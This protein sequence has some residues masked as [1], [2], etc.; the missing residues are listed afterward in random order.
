MYHRK[1]SI[2]NY[3]LD[4]FVLYAAL[5]VAGKAPAVPNIAITSGDEH[6]LRSLRIIELQAVLDAIRSMV[7][8]LTAEDMATDTTPTPVVFTNGRTV[9]YPSWMLNNRG[10]ELLSVYQTILGAA[11][12]N[13]ATLEK[14]L[15]R[16]RLLPNELAD[17]LVTLQS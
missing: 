13:R 4:P 2:E 8:P 12:V 1:Y 16:V 15:R 7:E 5:S 3:L 11:V 6:R 10:H 17:L 14:S 9:N